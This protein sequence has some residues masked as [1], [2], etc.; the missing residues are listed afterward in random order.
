ME[1]VVKILS[2]LL[3]PVI[4]VVTTYIAVQQYR[5]AKFKVRHE[6]FE[7]RLAVY[8]AVVEYLSYVVRPTP[9]ADESA[10]KMIRETADAY[11]L[12]RPELTEYLHLLYTKG[13]DLWALN[14]ELTDTTMEK[15]ERKHK[16]VERGDLKKW[17]GNQYAVVMERFREYLALDA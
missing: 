8:K 6:L 9:P 13:I 17:F 12:F 10:T 3:T 5:L 15:E 14:E 1:D 16:A 2:A 7:R 4:A 11:F